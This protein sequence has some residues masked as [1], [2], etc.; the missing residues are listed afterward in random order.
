MRFK[1]NLSPLVYS[2][3]GCVILIAATSFV[4]NILTLAEV[5]RF[6]AINKTIPIISLICCTLLIAFCLLVILNSAYIVKPDRVTAVYGVFFLSCA[7]GD[8]LSVLEEK[9]TNKIFIQ[10]VDK[11]N[12]KR[13]FS[14]ACINI[15]S[16]LN[17]DFIKA[18]IDKNADIKHIVVG[19]LTDDRN[20]DGTDGDDNYNSLN[21]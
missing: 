10:F 15:K 6:F 9:L 1:M 18:L 19:S 8:I 2:L 21:D 13:E 11:H 16:D 12:P 14:Y 20:N 7:I 5:G 17:A 4:M 3:L